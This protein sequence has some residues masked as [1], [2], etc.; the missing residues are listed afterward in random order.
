M[1]SVSVAELPSIYEVDPDQ[2]LRREIPLMWDLSL[3]AHIDPERIE[4]N[5]ERLRRIHKV[6]AFSASSVAEYYGQTDDVHSVGSVNED[7]SITAS[8]S[9]QLRKADP[10]KSINIDLIDFGSNSSNYGYPLARH[11][12]N[13][14]Q[15]V[16]DVIDLKQKNKSDEKAWAQVLDS[17]IRNSLMINAHKNLVGRSSALASLYWSAYTPYCGVATSVSAIEGRLSLIPVIYA[18]VFALHTG[19]DTKVMSKVNGHSFIEQ[20]RWSAFVSDMQIDRY[21]GTCALAK[22]Q[23]LITARP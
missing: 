17:S 23:K 21:V 20:R 4:V 12:L 18:T 1:N 15:V 13:R 22:T 3:P 7:G 14:E 16:D 9:R 5:I 6:G 11:I 19:I 10:S 8:K 2:I